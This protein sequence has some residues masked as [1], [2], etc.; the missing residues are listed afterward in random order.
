MTATTTTWSSPRDVYPDSVHSLMALWGGFAAPT[1]QD[2][3]G[4]EKRLQFDFEMPLSERRGMATPSFP[5][6][7]E[8]VAEAMSVADQAMLHHEVIADMMAITMTDSLVV[9]TPSRLL[10]TSSSA[11]MLHRV[12]APFLTLFAERGLAVEWAAFLRKNMLSPWDASDSETSDIMAEEYADL[13]AAFPSGH[14][15]LTGP[16]DAEHYFH[17]V[18]DNVVQRADEQETD[19][20]FNAYLF[21]VPS[22]RLGNKQHAE[23]HIA[24]VQCEMFPGNDKKEEPRMEEEGGYEMQRVFADS[25]CVSF[26]TNAS[27]Q[28]FARSRLPKLL[29]TFAPRR[30]T[31]VMFQDRDVPEGSLRGALR[32]V[33]GYKAINRTV[34]YFS[35]GYAFHHVNFERI[36][37][38]E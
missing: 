10:M 13:K 3:R 7:V 29:T 8:D 23:Q 24:P 33:P 20:Q 12:L 1:Q 30:F 28:T 19:T 15:F 34:N 6:T 4:L 37:D 32:A 18:F 26:E 21:E 14:S 2:D 27:I 11:V 25:G 5:L 38:A 22:E 36:A 35:E 17:F 9:L 16:V 31:L